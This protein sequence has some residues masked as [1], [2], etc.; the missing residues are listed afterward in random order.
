MLNVSTPL[1]Q[2]GTTLQ[3]TAN[4]IYDN[5]TLGNNHS[6]SGGSQTVTVIE[7]R[8]VTTKSVTPATAVEAGDGVELRGHVCQ[9]GHQHQPMM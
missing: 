6:V 9:H 2:I 5:P 8:I 4:L 3:N 7:P 1:N